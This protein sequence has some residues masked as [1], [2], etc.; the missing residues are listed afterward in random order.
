MDLNDTQARMQA[1]VVAV[2]DDLA[3][4]R[5]G[6]AVPALVEDVVVLAYGGTQQLKVMEMAGIHAQD[7]QSLVVSPWDKSVIGEI[8]KAINAAN[9]GLNAV[10]D[11]EVIRIQVPAITEE[12]RLELVKLLNIKLE[13]GKVAVRQVR[14]DKMI[15]IKKAFESKELN[16]DDKFN[17]EKELQETTDKLVEEIETLG[18]HKEAELRGE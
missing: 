4:I 15:H 17:L 14:H 11:N 7:A 18:K 9:L 16:E 10:I 5:V 1:A 3:T 8:A 2:R 13:H 12:R 6:R